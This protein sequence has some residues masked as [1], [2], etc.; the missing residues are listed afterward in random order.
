MGF[1]AS[2]GTYTQR[3]DAIIAD[4]PRKTKCIDNTI[5]WNTPSKPLMPPVQQCLQNSSFQAI[6]AD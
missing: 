3:C 5:L 1:L 2:Q 6:A 4:V